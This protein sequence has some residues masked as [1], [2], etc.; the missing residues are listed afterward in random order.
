MKRFERASITNEL[1]Q[2]PLTI[3]VKEGIEI[4]KSYRDAGNFTNPQWHAVERKELLGI[5]DHESWQEIEQSLVTADMEEESI[6]GIS[7]L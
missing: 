5:L 2:A 3:K 6:K 4:P 7:Y 1:K